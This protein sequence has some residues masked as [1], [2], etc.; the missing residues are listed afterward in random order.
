MKTGIVGGTFDVLHDGHKSLLTTAFQSGEYVYVGITD[1][2]M[3]NESRDRQVNDYRDRMSQVID[4]CE[5]L[6][7]IFNCG[8][9][10][11]VIHDPYFIDDDNKA[12][13]FLTDFIVI[14]PEE[15]TRRRAVEINV[16]RIENG[17]KPLQIIEAPMVKD[18]ENRKISSTRI[19]NDEIDEHG[20]SIG[21][22]E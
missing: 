11:N 9:S 21:D 5:T 1:N 10:V 20:N 2:E 22:Y 8:F 3:A 7:N 16:Q 13:D 12:E 4:Y 15:K 19:R 6:G 18:H 14:S 17:K